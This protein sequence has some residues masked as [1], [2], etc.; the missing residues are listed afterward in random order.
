[1]HAQAHVGG[2]HIGADVQAGAV[3]MGHPVL[4]HPNQ[5]FHSLHEVFGRDGRNAHAVAAV[6]KAVGV[7]VGA[8]QLDLALG[9]AVGL[10]ALEQLLGIVE[11][12]GGGVEAEG[13][14]GHDAGVMPALALRVIHHKHVIGK[15]LAEAQLGLVGGLR[16]RTG[17]FFNTDVQHD[18]NPL[19]CLVQEHAL[20][21]SPPIVLSCGRAAGRCP[22]APYYSSSFFP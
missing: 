3:G 12:H 22:A 17:G 1:M 2:E 13:A 19:F 20:D 7:A 4:F 15:N 9:G 6:N 10:H 5:L 18:D 11:D 16:L 14:V 8:E 21:S